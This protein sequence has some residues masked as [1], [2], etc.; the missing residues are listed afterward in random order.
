VRT[1]RIDHRGSG[2]QGHQAQFDHQPELII[3]EQKQA[4]GSQTHWAGN[5]FLEILYLR[6]GPAR[7]GLAK[8]LLGFRRIFTRYINAVLRLLSGG[9]FSYHNSRKTS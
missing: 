6:H 4:I 8:N 2:N 5:L 1:R 9:I 7:L 3:L